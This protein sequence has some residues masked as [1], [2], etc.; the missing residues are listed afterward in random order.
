M[1]SYKNKMKISISF[2]RTVFLRTIQL[3]LITVAM[4]I[5]SCTTNRQLTYMNNI[6]PLDSLNYYPFD[7]PDYRLQKQDILYVK[8][9]TLNE[10]LND[11][12]N[13]GSPINNQNMFQSERGIYINGFSITDS[14]AVNLPV[15]GNVYV[16]GMTIPEAR[17]AIE[18][19]A[20]EFINEGTVIVKLV[21][22]K[23]TILGEVNVPGTYY[24]YK[25]HLNVFEALGMAS[26]ITDYGDRSKILIIRTTGSGSETYWLNLSSKDI[27]TNPG[28]FLMPNDVLIVN[29][30]S[31]KFIELNSPTISFSL[32]TIV[33]IIS[34]TLLV[35][36]L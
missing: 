24:I 12:L 25:S 32:S 28:Y 4:S 10:E 22:F 21:N 20:S 5:F 19:A 33:A 15:I 9:T 3:L 27:L 31:A 30:L 18:K 6:D 7:F 11:A 17:N 36:S 14:G 16:L 8:F 34:L 1:F 26:D 29:P 13:G 2:K 35:L 23:V